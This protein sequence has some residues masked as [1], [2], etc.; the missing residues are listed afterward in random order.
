MAGFS[1]VIAG[2]IDVMYLASSHGTSWGDAFGRYILPAL[3]GNILGGVSL[4]AALNHAQV[5]AGS[6]TKSE[7]I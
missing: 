7:E 5:V 4:V 1:H 2:A 6:K 3:I